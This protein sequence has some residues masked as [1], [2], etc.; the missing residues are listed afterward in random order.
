MTE[1][2]IHLKSLGK[3]LS[4]ELIPTITIHPLPFY[5]DFLWRVNIECKYPQ[6][7]NSE[8]KRKLIQQVKKKKCKRKCNFLIDRK[9]IQK[10]IA[11]LQNPEVMPRYI[12]KETEIHSGFV[13]EEK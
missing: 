3:R 2:T 10:I 1:E 8:K 6:V 12:I 7:M 11:L 13:E 9:G 4:N 5:P